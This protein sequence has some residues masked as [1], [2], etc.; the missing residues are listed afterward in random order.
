VGGRQAGVAPMGFSSPIVALAMLKITLHNSPPHAR[1]RSLAL[2]GFRQKTRLAALSRAHAVIWNCRVLLLF[3]VGD[4]YND[5]TCPF[6]DVFPEKSKSYGR[7][8]LPWK[9]CATVT[10][11]KSM[12]KVGLA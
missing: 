4:V 9:L 10:I 5:L 7:L 6:Y 3:C 2:R 12:C 11:R 1:A 8:A